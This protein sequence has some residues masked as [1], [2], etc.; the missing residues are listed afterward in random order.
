[1]ATDNLGARTVSDPVTIEVLPW[2][3]GTA[4]VENYSDTEGC[5]LCYFTEFGTRQVLEVALDLREPVQWTPISTNS[6]P[7][8]FLRVTDTN[9]QP[10]TKKFY[11][12]KQAR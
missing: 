4:V 5:R 10:F 6:I 7:S 11:R 9:V 12:F 3:N 2:P 8:P 1:M